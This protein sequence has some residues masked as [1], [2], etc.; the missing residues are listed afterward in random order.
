MALRA[1]GEPRARLLVRAPKARIELCRIGAGRGPG[2]LP[3]RVDFAQ[4]APELRRRRIGVQGIEALDQGRALGAM[5]LELRLASVE[6]CIARTEDRIDGCLE[7]GPQRALGGA[8][9]QQGLGLLLPFGLQFAHA[10]HEVA[11]LRRAERFGAQRPGA[12]DELFAPQLGAAACDVE[13]RFEPRHGG[14]HPLDEAVALLARDGVFDRPELAP[15]GVEVVERSRPAPCNPVPRRRVHR[16]PVRQ[17]P[18]LRSIAAGPAGSARARHVERPPARPPVR[19][20]PPAQRRNAATAH[21]SSRRPGDR[22]PSSARAA[23]R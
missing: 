7:F 17:R 2:A 16:P 6:G 12:L 15:L 11:A 3:L 22:A 21:D 18:A 1:A 5:G 20:L 10:A 9:Q 23:R 13:R 4:R 14:A 8:R 19:R